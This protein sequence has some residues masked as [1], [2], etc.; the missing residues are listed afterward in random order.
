ML[1]IR[2]ALGLPHIRILISSD[3]KY[4]QLPN[5]RELNRDWEDRYFTA[6]IS[7]PP[8]VRGSGP[9]GEVLLGNKS[10]AGNMQ[11]NL[12]RFIRDNNNRKLTVGQSFKFDILKNLYLKI[13]AIWCMMRT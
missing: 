7:C 11:V 1:I 3:A 5:G 2:F 12:G 13:G 10:D 9:N 8:T 6:I 4:N